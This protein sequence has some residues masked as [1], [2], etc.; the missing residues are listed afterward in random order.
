MNPNKVKII[1]PTKNCSPPQIFLVI[2]TYYQIKIGKKIFNFN[3]IMVIY[4]ENT[5]HLKI[6]TQPY[7]KKRILIKANPLAFLPKV[8]FKKLV[9]NRI[10]IYNI[11][12]LLN[13]LRI[14]N[15]NLITFIKKPVITKMSDWN[16]KIFNH[17]NIIILI[18]I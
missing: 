17:T 6:P 16:K 7:P 10:P 2:I 3:K 5:K 12:K 4:Q 18:I 8:W 11:Q 15:N 14:N 1:F 13:H 9:W